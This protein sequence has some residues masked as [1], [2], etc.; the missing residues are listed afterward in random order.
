VYGWLWRA[1]PGPVAVRLL[2]LVVAGAALV[3]L[4]FGVVFP[5]VAPLVPVNDGTVGS[6][7]SVGVA[8]LLG[9]WPA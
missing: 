6:V 7:G 8:R 4:L 3:A 1:L 2:L 5:A 9:G